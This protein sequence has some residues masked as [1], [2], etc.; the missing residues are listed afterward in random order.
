MCTHFF[1]YI[2]LELFLAKN[3]FVN[4]FDSKNK[5]ILNLEFFLDLS[6]ILR[7]I[8]RIFVNTGPGDFHIQSSLTG[9]LNNTVI[10]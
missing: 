7:K 2:F 9:I 10:K 4:R 1:L 3:C 8:L 5:K 6:V